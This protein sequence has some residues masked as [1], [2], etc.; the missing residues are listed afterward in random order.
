MKVKPPVIA[1]AGKTTSAHAG[2]KLHIVRRIRNVESYFEK[3]HDHYE[4]EV[5]RP[6]CTQ[7][8]PSWGRR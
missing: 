2:L 7:I 5:P 8:S 6:I 3:N 1:E 4:L